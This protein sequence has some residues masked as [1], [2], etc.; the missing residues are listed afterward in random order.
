MLVFAICQCALCGSGGAVGCPITLGL[1]DQIPATPKSIVVSL[2]R[3]FTHIVLCECEWIVGG[4]RAA[5]ATH[6][7]RHQ[8]A[9]VVNE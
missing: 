7:A 3:H 1:V 9:I 4:W 8:L 5:V 6:V 2:D